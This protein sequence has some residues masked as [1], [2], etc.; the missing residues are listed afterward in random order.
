[1]KDLIEIFTGYT[2]ENC[3]KKIPKKNVIENFTKI[4]KVENQECIGIKLIDESN[5]YG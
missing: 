5:F 1:M 3:I 2:I 4:L